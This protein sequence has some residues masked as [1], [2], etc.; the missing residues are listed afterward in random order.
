M[1]GTAAA[2]MMAASAHQPAV[3]VVA[4]GSCAREERPQPVWDQ[5]IAHEPDLFL[6]IGDNM[7]ADIWEV[8]GK[9]VMQPP[10]AAS[11]IADAYAVLAQQPGW[12]R[13][14][15]VCPVLAIWDDHDYGDND[16]GKDWKFK[17]E[18]QRMFADFYG[19]SAGHPIRQ[20]EGIY[21]AETFGAD[22]RR[23]QVIMLDTRYFRDDLERAADRGTRRGPYE[24]TADTSKTLLGEAQWSWLGEQ[25]REPAA[26]R[27]IATSIQVVADEHGFETW[28]NFPHERERLYALIDEADASGVVF[29]SGDRHLTEISRDVRGSAPYPMWDFTSSGMTEDPGA[30]RDANSWRIGPV[31]R[32]LNYGLVRINWGETA[33]ETEIVFEARGREDRLLTRQS[34]WLS[35]LRER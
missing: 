28:G 24:A 15:E 27:I 35:E 18:S 9:Q 30:A 33:E 21:H 19:Y 13:I 26:V 11:Y 16:A 7:Y 25:L 10:P 22:D 4:F 17:R 6:F 1:I 29:I 31:T 32:D 20:R 23:V 3:D 8:D 5:I 12:Q 2:M 34:I 14:N